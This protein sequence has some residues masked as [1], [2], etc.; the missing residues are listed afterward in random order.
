MG[1]CVCHLPIRGKAEK[2]NQT[3]SLDFKYWVSSTPH[4]CLSQLNNVQNYF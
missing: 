3:K 1:E 2:T 4:D